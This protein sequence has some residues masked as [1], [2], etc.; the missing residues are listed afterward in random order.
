MLWAW[1]AIVIWPIGVSATYACVLYRWR[2]RIDPTVDDPDALLAA[3]TTVLR[4]EA[5]RARN[6]RL[7][8]VVVANN[9]LH[10]GA[11][12]ASACSASGSATSGGSSAR[13]SVAN[14]LGG[15]AVTASRTSRT[16]VAT[17]LSVGWMRSTPRLSVGTATLP[18]TPLGAAF[19]KRQASPA[20]SRAA[21]RDPLAVAS[22]RC[23]ASVRDS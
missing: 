15:G 20:S 9:P 5:D 10:S 18:Q 23:V 6:A 2:H 7:G 22:Q 21:R 19:H 4:R 1:V 17:R 14:P 11:A 16:F 13:F 8:V 12:A 3:V